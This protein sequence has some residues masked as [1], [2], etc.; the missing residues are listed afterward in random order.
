MANVDVTRIASNIGAA[1]ALNSLTNINKQLSIH[2]GRLSTGKRINSAGDDPAGLTIATKMLARSEGLKTSIG[3]ISDASNMLAVAEGGMSKMTDIMTQM[4]SLAETA[5]SDTLGSTER[6]AIATQLSAYS[7]QIQDVVDQTK[8]NG[9]KLLDSSTGAKTF[10]TGVDEGEKTTWNLP[11]ALDPTTMALSK[12][13][14][15]DTVT[16]Q[17]LQTSFQ[18]TSSGTA[19]ST[20]GTLG[21]MSQ[22]N[23]GDY[24]FKVLDKATSATVGKSTV[25]SD[26]SFIGGMKSFNAVAGAGSG[27]LGTNY[28]DS[29]TYTLKVLN[30]ASNSDITFQLTK[31]GDT[32]FGSNG[33]LTVNNANL[34]TDAAAASKTS[35]TSGVATGVTTPV[36]WGGTA[37]TAQTAG[38]TLGNNAGT[39]TNT[40][41]GTGSY[42]VETQSAVTAGGVKTYSYRLLN[43]TSGQ[44]EAVSTAAAGTANGALSTGGTAAAASWVTITA[45][46]AV[47]TGRGMTFTLGVS[48]NANGTNGAQSSVISYTGLGS[49]GDLMTASSV[50]AG[51]NKLGL[52]V[53]SSDYSKVTSGQTMS[54]EYLAENQAKVS[55]VDGSGLAQTIARG[56]DASGTQL[57][58]STSYVTQ[59]A[60]YQSGRGISMKLAAFANISTST[61]NQQGFTFERQNNYSVNVS[62]ALKAGSY[63]TTVNNALDK[64]TGALSDLGSLQARLTFKSSQAAVDQV[65]VEASYSRI[66]N[67]NMAEEQ[68]NASKFSILQQTAVA[69]LA[70]A[71]QAPQSL[72]SL[73]R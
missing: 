27:T 35:T 13:V 2:Q 48:A 67:A 57:T 62:T 1:N 3:N 55:L 18:V 63:M 44:Y 42:T 21:N 66:M 14:T 54:F 47:D 59:G 68:M 26:S 69:M 9:V 16:N 51:G 45:P 49:S 61:N 6:A 32:S 72:L 70:Q 64:V 60:E 28:M 39:G 5:A 19:V 37:V 24:T 53:G 12:K 71:N 11:G 33:V 29:G 30:A 50:L 22:L 58:G 10:Q 4:R 8:W 40:Q 56:T 20:S 38:A 15:T 23:T 52:N 73:F 7:Q 36:N 46:G 65:N 34:S 17:T 43:N 25:D 41:L 31:V